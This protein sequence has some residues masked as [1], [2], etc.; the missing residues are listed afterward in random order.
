M[1]DDINLFIHIVEIGN[2]HQASRELNVAQSTITRRIQN[3]ED[4]L[5][6]QL[7]NRNCRTFQ[8][9]TM[10]RQFYDNLQPEFKK[11]SAAYEDS[12]ATFKSLPGKI[13]IAVSGLC[14][15]GILPKIIPEFLEQFPEVQI[16]V[17]RMLRP[18][19]FNNDNIN[20]AISTVHP[21]SSDYQVDLI[22]ASYLKL[23]ATNQYIKQFGCPQSLEELVQ[24]HQFILGIN[25]DGSLVRQLIATDLK[26]LEEY[27]V[28]VQSNIHSHQSKDILEFAKTNKYII[29]SYEFTTYSEVTNGNLVAVLP[30]FSFGKI[31]EYL[32][33]PKGQISKIEEEFIKFLKC[34]LLLNSQP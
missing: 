7:F 25:P 5:G 15:Q 17:D 31:N 8:L 13:K 2:F 4:S 30:G 27:V 14:D 24:N 6:I 21:L 3:L 18:I 10:G 9:T 34:K 26:S 20:I 1:F 11:I 12:L 19:D 33:Y 23:Y 32:I 29:L 28:A 16:V 22:Q